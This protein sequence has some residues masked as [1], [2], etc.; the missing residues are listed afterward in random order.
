MVNSRIFGKKAAV[1][2]LVALTLGA[3]LT[4][5]AGD[6]EARNG[7]KGAAIAAGLIGALAVG[8]LVAGASNS[9]ASPGYYHGNPGYEPEPVYYPQPAPTYEPEPAYYG[10][11]HGY[12]H[13]PRAYHHR[14]YNRYPGYTET[15]FAYRGPVCK[16]KKQTYFDGYGYQVQ[17]VQVCR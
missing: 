4:V 7:R 9:H 2:A 3:G 6:A 16:I 8:A 13:Q 12:Y 1:A 10:G 15:G 5:N 11:H 17:R 14:R